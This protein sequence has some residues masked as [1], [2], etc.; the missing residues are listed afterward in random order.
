MPRAI[1]KQNEHK[2]GAVMNA[3]DFYPAFVRTARE[4]TLVTKEMLPSF[5]EAWGTAT[6]LDLY[7]NNEPAYTELVNK[8]IVHKIIEDAGMTAQHEYF[9]I[10]TVGWITRYQEMA[11]EAHKLDLSA[12]LWDLE[13]AVEHENSKQDWTDE[14]IKLIHVKCP[15]KVVIS[16]SHC[17]E[18]D[19]TE[20]KKLK[21]IARWMQEVKAFAKGSDEEYLLIFGNCFNSKTKADYD[22]FDYRG[23]LY[24]RQ[25]RRFDR[26]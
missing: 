12:H 10:D 8:Y 11:E 15:L 1:L 9:R 14:V 17:D 13:I 2:G 20:W 7:R 19:T 26:I 5:P 25:T 3:R 4:S 23:Y 16:Y 24:N 18:R 22:T 6:F 21:F